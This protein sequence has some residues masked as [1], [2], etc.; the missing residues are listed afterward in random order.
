MRFEG[1]NLNQ[2][3][4]REIQGGYIWS[5]KKK[6]NGANGLLLTPTVDHLFDRE[7]RR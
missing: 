5:P 2:T 4:R 3:Y 6:T 1:V 7:S